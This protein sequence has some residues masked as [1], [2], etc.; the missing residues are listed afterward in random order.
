MF[1][2]L[3]EGPVWLELKRAHISVF[4][5]SLHKIPWGPRQQPWMYTEWKKGGVMCYTLCAFNDGIL[6]I[7]MVR[8]YKDKIIDLNRYKDII[9]IRSVKDV[10]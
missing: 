10:K 3:E 6:K 4:K 9:L 8:I 2:I 5:C 7:P 1:A